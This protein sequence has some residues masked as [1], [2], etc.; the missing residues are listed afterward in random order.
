MRVIVVGAGLAGLSAADRLHRAGH[1]VVVLEA[2]DRV[3]GRVWSRRLDN[4]AVVEMGA[5]FILPGNTLIRELAGRLGL[6]LWD[7]GMRYGRREPRGVDELAPGTLEAAIRSVDDTLATDSDLGRLPAPRLLERLE[8]DPTATA[9]LLA[10]LEVSTASP[11]DAVPAAALS[12][13]AHIGDEPA[14]SVAGG[15]Q[16]LARALARPL[17]SAIQLGSAARRIAWGEDS[18]TVWAAGSELRA[19]ACVIAVPA[20]TI[21]DLEFEPALPSPFARAARAI[22]Y[23]QAAKLFVPLLQQAPPSAVMSVP[24]RYWTWTSTGAEGRVQPVVN[25]FAGSAPALEALAV[26]SGPDRW[27]ASLRELRPDLE[28]DTSDALL[29]T[30]SDDPWVRGAYSTLPSEEITQVLSRRVGPLSFAGEHTGGPF[31]GLMEGALRSG[32]RAA[33][34]LIGQRPD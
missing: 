27:V 10:R 29:S 32:R 30:W 14:P 17:G 9:V 1:E 19:D 18:V 7:K 33:A 24:E 31:A 23:G 16:S 21:E 34:C 15:N 4:G 22:A 8:I 13:V 11:A 2:R 12:G 5:E 3:G 6:E 26:D 28:L 25:A 20:T